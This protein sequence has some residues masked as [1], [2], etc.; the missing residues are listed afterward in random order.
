M[1]Q[2]LYT[3]THATWLGAGATLPGLTA[4]LAYTLAPARLSAAAALASTAAGSAAPAPA[5]LAAATTLASAADAAATLPPASLAA[6]AA[7]ATGAAASAPLASATLAAEA[8]SAITAEATVTVD[9]A[10]LTGKTESIIAAAAQL[11]LAPATLSAETLAAIAASAAVTLS[12]ARLAATASTAI[13]ATLT[14]TLAPATLDAS[15]TSG[16][17]ARTA[18]LSVALAPAT[19]S[20]SVTVLPPVVVPRTP[21]REAALAAIAA[22]L[23]AAIPAAT[24]ERARRAPVDTDRERLPR[25]VVALDGW[26]ADPDSLPGITSYSISVLITGYAAGGDDASARAALAALLGQVAAALDGW[27]PGPAR[28]GEL[29]PLDADILL[30]DAADSARPAG[31]LSARYDLTASA[32]TGAP[33]LN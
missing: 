3:P 20:A 29:L 17:E 2:P 25:L 18:T 13:G 28:L 19:L 31:E 32:P 24:V 15:A 22:R 11:A 23:A 10:S 33:Y 14:V 27:A 1:A 6:A 7:V 8:A 21:L 16:L 9:R 26:Q 5:T 12:P 30:Y 4:D